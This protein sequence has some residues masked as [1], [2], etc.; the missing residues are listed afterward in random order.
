MY[1]TYF[2][3]NKQRVPYN[4][5]WITVRVW[6]YPWRVTVCA[7]S[8]TVWENPTRGIPVFNP[9]YLDAVSGDEALC[10]DKI[11]YII[12]AAKSPFQ[13]VPKGKQRFWTWWIYVL[14]WSQ[15]AR[16]ICRSA[17]FRLLI[18]GRC[19]WRCATVTEC[20][21]KCRVVRSG[22]SW[23]KLSNKPTSSAWMSGRVLVGRGMGWVCAPRQ[24]TRIWGQRCLYSS[25]GSK[26]RNVHLQRSCIIS[27]RI[28]FPWES[29]C[30]H[31]AT[32]KKFQICNGSSWYLLTTI[33]FHRVIVP[34]GGAW[35][36]RTK[37]VTVGCTFYSHNFFLI[38]VK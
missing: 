23:S 10:N 11:D 1:L 22:R 38:V 21:R 6:V 32:I 28:R 5:A 26:D 16:E 9:N 18:A 14:M 36:E 3:E 25:N 7:G 12:F 30:S 31:A 8:G 17:R 27:P 29:R 35:C 20:R 34:C 33:D 2:N 19:L 24:I 37:T 4:T 13:P 15:L